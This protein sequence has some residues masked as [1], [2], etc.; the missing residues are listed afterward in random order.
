M[1][2]SWCSTFSLSVSLISLKCHGSSER[3]WFHL[4]IQH[5]PSVGMPNRA[6]V[7][8]ATFG[9][10]LRMKSWSRLVDG[11]VLVEKPVA[12]LKIQIISR[13]FNQS[14]YLPPPP[15]E[16]TNR[17]VIF[18]ADLING[19]ERI[20]KPIHSRSWGRLSSLRSPRSP[21]NQGGQVG[22]RDTDPET[23][24]AR[25]KE[26]EAGDIDELCLSSK[27]VLIRWW[28]APWKPSTQMVR[29]LSISVY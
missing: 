29:P 13:L 17:K 2:A 28:L 23:V 9:A 26:R 8:V 15:L 21:K 5:K 3:N 25:E 4:L 20:V 11:L 12:S 14:I 22:A 16:H 6:A 1:L 27:Q 18:H 10:L 7:A 19:I 24:R